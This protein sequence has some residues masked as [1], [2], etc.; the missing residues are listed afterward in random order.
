MLTRFLRRAGNL[1]AM[2]SVVLACCLPGWGA[3]KISVQAASDVLGYRKVYLVPIKNDRFKVTA[4]LSNRLEKIGFEVVGLTPGNDQFSAQGSGFLVT[5]Q[6]DVLTCAHVVRNQTSAT[7]WVGGVRH[8][9]RVVAA[10]TNLDVAVIHIEDTHASFRPVPFA[11]DN[12][13]HLGEDVFTMGFPL[14]DVLG[15]QPR[16]NKGLINSTTGLKDNPTTLQI[17]AEVQA[18]NSGGPLFNNRGELIG[19]VSSTLNPLAILALSGGDL[20]QNVNFAIK[21]D[22]LRE[23]LGTAG[24]SLRPGTNTNSG[25]VFDEAAKSIVLVRSG[26]VDEAQIHEA[27]LLCRCFYIS[28]SSDFVRIRLDFYDLR[29]L[30]LVLTASLDQRTTASHNSV[31]DHFF[32]QIGPHFFPDSSGAR[33]K[34]QKK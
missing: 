19:M 25:E 20:P 21:E 12:T 31:L 24:V 32:K 16:L 3:P 8:V 23:F 34:K 14:A 2:A 33:A 9:G 15:S 29:I 22:P 27:T 4:G 7:L 1:L 26:I 13:Y 17:S 10:D 28:S 30:K 11:P 18:G 6:G 5:P